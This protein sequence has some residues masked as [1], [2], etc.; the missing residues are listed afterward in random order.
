MKRRVLLLLAA[1]LAL[2]MTACD[3][4]SYLPFGSTVETVNPYSKVIPDELSYSEGYTP[5]EST[6]SYQALTSESER[7]LYQRLMEIL[8]DISSEKDE[9]S[10]RYPMPEIEL[11]GYP[12]REA[13]MRTALK[14]VTDDHPEIFWTTGTIGF[15]ADDSMTVVQLYSSYSPDEVKV[16]LDAVRAEANAFYATVPDGL[17]EYERELMVHDYL[18]DHVEYDK[19]V[20]LEVTSNNDP[21]I[22]TVYG[23]LVNRV[24][25]CEGYARSFQMLMNGLGVECVGVMGKSQN[26][27]HI[28][29]AVK[30]GSGWYNV[31]ATWDD[32]EQT[33]AHYL[34]FNIDDDLLYQDH[35][36]SP[37]VS[38]MSDA[39]ING[40]EG[41]FSAEVM[42]LF[43]PACTDST[44]GYYYREL[45]HLADYGGEEIKSGLLYTAQA[46]EPYFVFYVDEV[47][48]YNEAISLL[49]ADYPQYFFDYANAVNNYLYDY[50]IDTSN[51]SY[52]IREPN[53]I[54]A[55]ELYYY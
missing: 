20:D 7:V 35:E 54:V 53:R 16:C 5:I 51:M 45:P 13:Q 21:D 42:N 17:S 36:L 43:A 26:Q 32:Q 39:A 14:A 3:M 9:T 12:M 29:N 31:D 24:A 37:M 10:G 27:M 38:D 6:Y 47:L 30:L 22:Y 34:Y 19:N 33:Y 52:F 11:K 28:W 25:V 46:Q 4:L 40:D 41:E 23:A 2:L 1:V 55:V 48:D 15:Y 50:S 18:I 8:Y 44:M 49:F